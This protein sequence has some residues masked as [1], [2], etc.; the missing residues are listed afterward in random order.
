MSTRVRFCV[1]LFWLGV[2]VL[3][4]PPR[5]GLADQAEDPPSTAAAGDGPTDR[6]GSDR[7]GSRSAGPDDRET[8][9]P[10]AG[11]R[12]CWSSLVEIWLD[13]PRASALAD[14]TID[15]LFQ[16]PSGRSLVRDLCQLTATS[17]AR[18]TSIIEL[19]FVSIPPS[20][21]ED[22]DGC[23]S[24]A[25]PG[26]SRYTVMVRIYP[27]ED[28]AQEGTIAFGEYP[29][30]TDCDVVFLFNQPE[31]WMAQTL[32]HELLHLWFI[33]AFPARTRRFPTGHGVATRC[34]FEPEFLELL[35]L[36]AEELAIAEG[37]LRHRLI[38]RPSLWIAH[39]GPSPAEPEIATAPPG[40]APR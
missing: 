21:S 24:P 11:D 30:S 33:H 31:S 23:F 13:D 9:P 35:D 3:G 28:D 40:D 37:R 36:N 6:S 27:E 34:E 26:A 32:Y 16:T 19:H 29:G 17:P 4:Q 5:P 14:R 20:C 8:T 18:S 38:R 22:S 10:A 2:S 7:T 15:R 39:G 25:E 12:S 1:L